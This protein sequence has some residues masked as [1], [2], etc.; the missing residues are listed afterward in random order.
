MSTLLFVIVYIVILQ[1][2]QAV[3]WFYV[4]VWIRFDTLLTLQKLANFTL[5]ILKNVTRKF[6][7]FCRFF[8]CSFTHVLNYEK[9]FCNSKVNRVFWKNLFT[10][11]TPLDKFMKCLRFLE[12]LNKSIFT[13][14]KCFFVAF[15]EF[16]M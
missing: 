14:F 13:F 6:G 11:V 5:S 1:H 2:I 15:S 16:V 9:F 12:C 10:H 7:V 4:L 8:S 3:F